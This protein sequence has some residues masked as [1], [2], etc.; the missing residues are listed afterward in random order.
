MSYQTYKKTLVTIILCLIA[1]FIID[2]LDMS[3]S[4][5]SSNSWISMICFLS[6]RILFLYLL[7]FSIYAALL[8]VKDVR[9]LEHP[10]FFIIFSFLMVTLTFWYPIA[11]YYVKSNVKN[12]KLH[13]YDDMQ[14]KKIRQSALNMDTVS[15]GRYNF[16]EQYF[17]STGEIIPYLNDQNKKI[18]Y[19]PS[20]QIKKLEKTF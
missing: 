13:V 3:I 17:L 18:F 16:A 6:Y 2:I 5:A 1:V 10:I 15:W 14:L 8:R 11:I 4:S 19:A 20:E 12:E 7:C 9:K